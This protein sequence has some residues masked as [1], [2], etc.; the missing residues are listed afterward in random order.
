M[1]KKNVEII[2]DTNYSITERSRPVKKKRHVFGTIVAV[3]ISL[4]LALFMRYYI[5][6]SG[7]GLKQDSDKNNENIGMQSQEHEIL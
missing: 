1:P 3:I 2:N 5:E 4:I 7:S 6:V